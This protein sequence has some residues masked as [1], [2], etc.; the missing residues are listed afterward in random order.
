MGRERNGMR[1]PFP[2]LVLLAV[3]LLSAAG[4]APA[5][6][7][8]AAADPHVWERWETSLRSDRTYPNPYADVSVQVT[9]EGPGGKTL[10]TRGYWDGGSTFK[11]RCAFPV[12]GE[13]QWRTTCSDPTNHS[14]HGRSGRVH[15]RRYTGQNPL[16]R[17]GFLK[18]SE[19]HRYLCH[20]DETPFLWMGDTAWAAPFRSQPKDWATYLRARAAQKFSVIQVAL[21]PSWA[22]EADTEGR[23]PFSGKGLERWNPE[24]WQ[25]YERKIQL[26]N[27]LGLV[28]LIVGVMEPTVRYP[29]AAEA[30]LFARQLAAR[31]YGNFVLY[32]PSFDSPYK[33][34][35]DQVGQSLRET[36]GV[37]LLTQH[38]GTPSGQ[39]T[40][41]FAEQYFDR[42]Y[43]DFSGD[44]SGHNGG[45]L[46]RCAAQAMSWNLHLYRRTPPKPVINLEAMYDAQGE[47]TWTAEDA[48]SLGYRSWLS[49]A[50]GYTYGAGDTAPNR[51]GGS[52][53]IWTW[54]T[55]SAKYDFWRKAVKWPSGQQMGY[56]HDFLAALPWWRLEPA[57]ELILTPSPHATEAA[58]A[59]QTPSNDLLIAY[60]PTGN[61]QQIDLKEYPHVRKARWFDPR[62]NRY[63]PL[64]G[65]VTGGAAARFTP[66]GSGDWVLVLTA[67]GKSKN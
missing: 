49:G 11:L 53:G 54:V 39:S 34:L 51:P 22:G 63:Q 58:C 32:S 19:D 13:W 56:L 64:E 36:T 50:K 10:R 15:V 48:R 66:P 9:Y 4:R 21:A 59:A 6:A 20:A 5:A 43:M 62:N 31:L 30:R 24:F 60:F 3:G 1:F 16:Y 35:A 52:G 26:A 25:A 42:P 67:A 23:T 8:P 37:H 33:E 40:N 65:K 14:L 38:P 44:Q 29:T 46:E 61:P 12:A 17:H 18:V 2:L 41:V 27:E 47:K 57:P 55:D 28:V 45:N 7:L